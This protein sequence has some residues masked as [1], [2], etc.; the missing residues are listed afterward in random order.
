M[1]YSAKNIKILKG[2]EAVR[3]RPGMYIGDT[4][5]RGLH[6]LI[7]EILDNSIDEAMADKCDKI[8]I[9]LN[10]EKNSITVEDNGR[11]IPVDIHPEEKV[12]AVEVVLTKLHAGGKFDEKAYTASGGLHGVGVSV[13]NALSSELIVRISRNK[14]IFEQT[15]SKGLPTSKLKTTGK[16]KTTGTSISFVPDPEIFKKL[17][18]DFKTIQSHIESQTYL[19]SGVTFYLSDGGKPV[20]YHSKN[21]LLDYIDKILPKKDRLATPIYVSGKSGK[22]K[23]EAVLAWMSKSGEKSLS[24]CNNIQ[25]TEGGTHITGFR[26][27][28]S[29][30]LK[31]V[32]PETLQKTKKVSVVPDDSR[33][34]L[35]SILSVK[36]PQPQFEG[37]TKTKLG[38]S[39]AR[40]AVQSIL[41]EKLKEYFEALKNASQIKIIQGKILDNARVREATQRAR[42]NARKQSTTVGFSLPGKLADCQEKDPARSEI[43]IVEGE[44]AGGCFPGDTKVRLLNGESLTF[45]EL[46]Q[47]HKRGIK[48]YGYAYNTK[49]KETEVVELKNPRIIKEVTELVE[50]ELSNGK[51]IQCTPDHKWMLR[52]GSYI[53]SENLK[54]Y[55]NLM[56][57]IDFV[58]DDGRRYVVSPKF[59]VNN[60]PSIR[61]KRIPV[62]DLSVN[63]KPNVI[64]NKIKLK[65]NRIKYNIHHKDH[66]K[67]NDLPDNL[68]LMIESYHLEEHGKET[69]AYCSFKSGSENIHAIKMKTDPDYRKWR[70]KKNQKQQEKYWADEKHRKTQ[71]K[72]ISEY[73]KKPENRKK[74]SDATKNG[75]I[76]IHLRISSFCSALNEVNYN[77]VKKKLHP[78]LNLNFDYWKKRFASFKD[79]AEAV[80]NYEN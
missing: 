33:E 58:E 19:N 31:T 13:V 20:K 27:G 37:Q 30:S 45:E 76:N 68:A 9:T 72:R 50:I 15:Y 56:P 38:T 2:L 34:G 71:S 54:Q 23:V 4:E 46:A 62:Y 42:E 61:G 7:W 77:R 40:G 73:F 67:Q 16:T 14:K 59:S 52:N 11:G 29:H 55:D 35:V 44:S 32:L 18:F 66:N 80:E 36:I 17:V 6:H 12:P 64:E 79:Y 43:F 10:K 26:G 39:D 60:N 41:T 49:E 28:L 63:L 48:H 65:R 69:S 51:K 74:A 5:E 3:K 25:T 8:S 21:G 75:L 22:I 70:T 53:E 57:H 24:F 1:T 47:E 78:K